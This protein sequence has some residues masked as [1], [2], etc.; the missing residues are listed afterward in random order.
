MLGL[1]Y[2]Q[3][4][5]L[6]PPEENIAPPISVQ[7][8]PSFG[9]GFP[10]RLPETEY[11]PLYELTSTD[12]SQKKLSPAK[13]LAIPAP[14]KEPQITAV[15]EPTLTNAIETP[16]ES[17]EAYEPTLEQEIARERERSAEEDPLAQQ[18]SHNLEHPEKMGLRPDELN[19]YLSARINYRQL[20][21][22]GLWA[23]TGSRMGIKGRYFNQVVSRPKREP[24]ILFF[25]GCIIWAMSHPKS[26]P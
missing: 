6:S 1:R 19:A 5:S 16:K 20:E 21:G 8:I 23:D 17:D 24:V 15:A 18:Q 13:K 4:P 11:G 10:Y 3:S 26:W 9:D 25:H 7:P 12:T 22:D 2:F 14:Q